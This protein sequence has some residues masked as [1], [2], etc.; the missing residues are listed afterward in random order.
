MHI[1]FYDF[2]LRTFVFLLYLLSLKSSCDLGLDGAPLTSEPL[3]PSATAYP[4]VMENQ[5]LFSRT[6]EMLTTVYHGFTRRRRIVSD[7]NPVQVIRRV[8]A[9]TVTA[10]WISNKHLQHY[11]SVSTETSGLLIHQTNESLRLKTQ[12][13]RWSTTVASQFVS[14]HWSVIYSSID[15]P[16]VSTPV[17]YTHLDVYKRQVLFNQRQLH[18]KLKTE[19]F[20]QVNVYSTHR[21]DKFEQSSDCL[22]YTSRC[23]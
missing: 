19:Q 23:V 5:A 14:D 7:P 13:N 6:S 12:T 2:G 21:N 16:T 8:A 17:S 3:V 9:F 4:S 22:L 15:T 11:P 10:P 18:L 1:Y 20:N